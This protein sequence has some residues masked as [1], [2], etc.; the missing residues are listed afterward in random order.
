MRVCFDLCTEDIL[1]L[2]C[3]RRGKFFAVVKIKDSDILAS[4]FAAANVSAG[5]ASRNHS[6]FSSPVPVRLTVFAL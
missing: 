6:G 4:F 5:G 3:E 1:D 2:F